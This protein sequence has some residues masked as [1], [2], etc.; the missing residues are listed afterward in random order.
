MTMTQLF[1]FILCKTEL[2]YVVFTLFLYSFPCFNILL[3]F[4][5]AFWR[6][7]I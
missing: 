4:C 3:C 5:A 7:I 1:V 2:V 6:N